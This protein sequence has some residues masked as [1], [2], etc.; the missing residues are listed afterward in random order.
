M[1]SRC[2]AV[3]TIL[4]DAMKSL[5]LIEFRLAAVLLVSGITSMRPECRGDEQAKNDRVGSRV[6]QKNRSFTLRTGDQ[7]IERQVPLDIWCVEKVEGPKLWIRAMHLDIVG[8]ARA[9][10]V[11][12]TNQAIAYFSD[13]IREHPRDAFARVS[14]AELWRDKEEPDKALAD[15]NEAVRIDPQSRVAFESRAKIWLDMTE[16]DKAITDCDAVLR[17]DP[18]CARAYSMRGTASVFKHAYDSAMIDFDQAIR[19]DPQQS[20]AFGNRGSIW[21]KKKEYDKAATDFSEAIRINPHDAAAYANRAGVWCN[22]GEYDKSIADCNVAIRLGS[23]LAAAYCHRGYAWTYKGDHAKAMAD[24]NEA[25]RLD[26]VDAAPFRNR[27][28]VWFMKKD[29]DKAIADLDQSIRLD[30]Q[31]AD[32]YHCRALVWHAKQEYDKAIADCTSAIQLNPDDADAYA[33]R[34]SAWTYR[35][36]FDKV[37]AD[38]TSAIQLNPHDAYVFE[39]R[40]HAWSRKQE[41]DKVIA[42]CT[43]AI[44]VDPKR[45]TSYRNRGGT[46]LWMRQYDKA[47]DDYSEA[48]RLEPKNPSAYAN[49]AV[50]WNQKGNKAKAITDYTEYIRL[51]PPPFGLPPSDQGSVLPQVEDQREELDKII[52]DCTAAIGVDPAVSRPANAP[53]S[54]AAQRDGS[55]INVANTFGSLFSEH[56]SEPPATPKGPV[57][58]SGPHVLSR[59]ESATKALIDGDFD[60]AIEQANHWTIDDPKAPRAYVIRARAWH[61]KGDDKHSLSELKKVTDLAPSDASA[62][63]LLAEIRAECPEQSLRGGKEAVAAATKSCELTDWKTPAYLDTLAAAYAESGDFTPAVEWETKALE[64][65]TLPRETDEYR[66]RLKLYQEKKPYHEAKP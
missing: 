51:D 4:E 44:R 45:A 33:L 46:W 31:S 37:I 52:A 9:D 42:D 19:L 40:A 57:L 62:W 34:A 28:Q 14:R 10:Q 26:P 8:W 6:V 56:T 27:G 24:L 53:P 36:D 58:A 49:R 47:I 55:D 41:F 20:V 61:A 50:A 11:V 29:F 1:R 35:Q 32:T 66:A 18:Q 48:I 3:L 39:L 63:D 12:S 13:Q 54:K 23:H 2:Q 15:C 64:R 25:I 65:E 16:F 7:G 30:P 22:K 5:M 43:D 59:E 60:A 21:L 38:C 17:I